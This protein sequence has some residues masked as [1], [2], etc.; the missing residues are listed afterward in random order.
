MLVNLGA[1]E[2]TDSYFAGLTLP[3]IVITIVGTSL[4]HVLVP[5]LAG[6]SDSKM[7]NDAWALFYLMGLFFF[8]LTVTLYSTANIW[9]PLMLPGF[10]SASIV[11]VVKVVHIQLIAMFFIGVNVV[12][13]ALLRAKS[14]FVWLESATLFGNIVAFLLLIRLLP[15]Y[16]VVIAAWINLLQAVLQTVLFLPIM[17]KP[18]II[19]QSTFS[20][21][22]V[23]KRLSPLLLGNLYFKS[24][25]LIDRFF[26]SSM[27]SGTL[28]L[29]YFAQQLYGAFNLLVNRTIVGPM[30]AKLST[31]YKQKD[32]SGFQKYYQRNLLIVSI[33]SI[34]VF[35]IVTF[36][37]RQVLDFFIGYGDLTNKNI[38][39]LWWL[40]ILLGGTL[41]GG[42]LGTIT[43][44]TFYSMGNTTM[45]TKIGIFVYPP[46]VFL[47]VTSFALFGLQG[48]AIVTSIYCLFN[49]LFQL[50]FLRNEIAI[51]LRS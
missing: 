41:V 5:F 40:M 43:T 38:D 36:V 34:F 46:Y 18:L 16:G 42:V 23:L 19:D 26:L 49:F 51:S 20:I 12:Q 3:T 50:Y 37:G 15:S 27:Q 25:I 32:L 21:K 30:V 24:D 6:E 11:L 7:R 47:K 17:G 44:S 2:S 31:M 29:Y 10:K 22:L 45:P 33:L 8:I 39:T 35:V 9:V 28:S 14:K 13:A 48:L 4:I 1:G